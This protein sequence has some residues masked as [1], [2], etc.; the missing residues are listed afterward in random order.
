MSAKLEKLYERIKICTTCPLHLSRKNAVPGEGGPESRLM[1]IGEAPGAR[2]DELGRPF[3]GQAGDFLDRLFT[4]VG[5]D[6]EKTYITSTVKCRPPQNRNPHKN[7]I[8]TCDALW[9][10][11]Q[12]ELVNPAVVVLLGIIPINHI[13]KEKR[14]LR[15]IHGRTRQFKGRLFLPTYHPAAAMRFPKPAKRIREDF[16]LIHRIPLEDE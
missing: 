1:L 15:D 11:R 9:L 6:R 5:L 7:E 2:E 12:I 14:T 16:S 13:L 4:E 8:N 10:N 3:C